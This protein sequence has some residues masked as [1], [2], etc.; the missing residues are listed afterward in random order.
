MLDLP[1]LEW[2]QP[3]KPKLWCDTYPVSPLDS[4]QS[5]RNSRFFPSVIDEYAN[6][7]RQHLPHEVDLAKD[8][9][10]LS[11]LVFTR[12]A[13]NVRLPELNKGFQVSR[14]G[15][16]HSRKHREPWCTSPT[17]PT[18]RPTSCLAA[19]PA[20]TTRMRRGHRWQYGKL[21]PIIHLNQ[22]CTTSKSRR[23][24]GVTPQSRRRAF[25]VRLRSRACRSPSLGRS[26]RSFPEEYAPRRTG[27]HGTF[28][29]ELTFGPGRPSRGDYTGIAGVPTQDQV[30]TESMLKKAIADRIK[31]LLRILNY[32]AAPF[33][34]AEDLWS[35]S[36]H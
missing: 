8:L 34:S 3:C 22:S 1:R 25:R 36:T 6:G 18:S 28:T 27:A 21:L 30:I 9:R 14:Q 11:E 19:V 5:A 10:A 35:S 24:T 17:G 15:T 4:C 2:S 13:A 31:E 16:A 33:G 12:A 23:Q 26:Q 20:P 32:L 29:S 7:L